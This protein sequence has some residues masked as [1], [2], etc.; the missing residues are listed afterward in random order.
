MDEGASE[1]VVGN[2]MGPVKR[3]ETHYFLKDSMRDL[4]E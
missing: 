3:K 4:V 1:I 2:W